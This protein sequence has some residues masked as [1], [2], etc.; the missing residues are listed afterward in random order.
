[1]SKSL[2]SKGYIFTVEAIV[3]LLVVFYLLSQT[4]IN[5]KVDLNDEILFMQVQDIVE[6]CS[7][8]FNYSRDCIEKVELVNQHIDV[9]CVSK[10]KGVCK[11]PIVQRDYLEISVTIT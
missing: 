8:Q 2:Q 7:K 11:N 9:T 5:E 10:I 1:M 3:C 6:V 4:S